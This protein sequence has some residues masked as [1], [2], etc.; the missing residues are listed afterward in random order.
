MD[1]HHNAHIDK[2]VELGVQKVTC[3]KLKT[4][5]LPDNQSKERTNV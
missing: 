2:P 1:D 5:H 4:L 3:T